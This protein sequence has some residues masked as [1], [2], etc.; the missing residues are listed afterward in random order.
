MPTT[1]FSFLFL[2]EG[3]LSTATA[4]FG[5]RFARAVLMLS[6]AGMPCVLFMHMKF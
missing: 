2:T 6:M 4:N 1:F 3:N 5:G